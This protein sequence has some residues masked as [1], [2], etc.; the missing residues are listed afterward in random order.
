MPPAWT[1]KRINAELTAAVSAIGHFPTRTE[2]VARGQRSLWEA[3]RRNGGI[4]HW[5]TK[6]AA[7]GR[8]DA[9]ADIGAPSHESIAVAA[10]YRHLAGGSD[11][12]SDW[13]AAEADLRVAA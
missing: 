3:M 12:L 6:V 8:P 13:F 11:P 5:Q 9:P 1:S 10:Y 2:L 7:T 4:E